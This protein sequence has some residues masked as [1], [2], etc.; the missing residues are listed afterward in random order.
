MKIN[1]L[2]FLTAATVLLSAGSAHAGLLIDFY[3]GGTY[4]IGGQTLIAGDDHLSTSAQSY[5]AVFGMNLPLLRIEGEYNYMNSDDMH[6]NLALV[7]AYI[8]LPTPVITPYI[9][10]GAGTTFSSQY[11]L[12]SH[13]NIDIQDAIAYQG[14][15]GVSFDLPLMPISIDVEGRVLYANDIFEHLNQEHDLLHYEGRLKI[16]YDF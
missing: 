10:V 3:A 6:L 8:K 9:G 14:M 1:S 2:G 5:G 7:N 16:R 4:G 15:L 11:H 12:T 13:T